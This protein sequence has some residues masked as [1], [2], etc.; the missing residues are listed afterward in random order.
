MIIQCNMK[1]LVFNKWYWWIS[2]D[3][4]LWSAGSFYDWENIEIRTNSRKFSLKPR[5]TSDLLTT[6][7][8]NPVMWYLSYDFSKFLRLHKNW[9]ITSIDENN[10]DNW[11]Y[12]TKLDAS[13]YNIWVIQTTS[14]WTKWFVI[15]S[16]KLYKWS[17]DNSVNSLWIYD[18][19][20]S[21]IVTTSDFSSA[22]WWTVWTWWAISWGLATHTAWWWTNSLSTTTSTTNWVTYRIEVRCRTITADSCQLKIWWVSQYTF[23]STDS[24][25]TVI[26]NYTA[27]ADNEVLEFVPF[28]NFAWSFDEVNWITYNITS[29][30]YNFNQYAPY[31]IYSDFI[32][33]WNGSKITQIDTSPSTWVISDV[34]T[35]DNWYTIKGIT[36]ISD[37]FLIY[38]T[39]WNNTRQYMWDWQSTT[40]DRIITWIDKPLLNVANWANIDYVI[41]GWTANGRTQLH[42]VNWYQLNLI[43]QSPINRDFA[44]ERIFLYP[45]YTNAIETLWN[46][47]IIPWIWCI[48]SYWQHTPWMPYSLVKDTDFNYN[49]STWISISSWYVTAM[50]YQEWSP[51][52]RYSYVWKEANWTAYIM[53]DYIQLNST[54]KDYLSIGWLEI[55]PVVWDTY[56]NIKSYEKFTLGYKMTW[57]WCIWV[58]KKSDWYVVLMTNK[59]FTTVPTTGATYTWWG[60]TFTVIS[61]QQDNNYT[62]KRIIYCSYTW[63]GNKDLE[64]DLTKWSWTWDTTFY[65][66]RIKWDWQLIKTTTSITDTKFWETISWEFKEWQLAISSCLFNSSKE[67]EIFDLNLYYNEVT[68][69]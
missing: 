41:T 9:Q 10:I 32:Y 37:Q 5:K 50:S 68:D 63:S 64:L 56:S 66:R 38:A 31:N 23:S 34:F 44:R 11:V 4:N 47:L 16:A 8:S 27:L 6:T 12:V 48:Y 58:Y 20:A 1:R 28:N 62:D 54:D 61:V 51:T 46:T 57:S 43:T 40:A 67:L 29:Q 33:V 60:Y 49:Y 45:S 21:W 18:N 39:D 22:T 35:I 24:N 59:D 15:W 14:Y 7:T 65:V 69:D 42:Q 3:P 19:I 30:A 36:R 25:K 13:C 17:Y 2:N 53:E 52:L 26:F 55:N